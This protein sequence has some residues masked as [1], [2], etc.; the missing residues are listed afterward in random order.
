MRL[1]RFTLVAAALALGVAACGD[2]VQVVEPTPPQPPPPPPVEATMAPAS[3]S[4]AVGNSVVFAVNASGGVAGEAASWTCSSSNT[5]IATVTSTSAGC[6]ATGV[7]AGDVTITASVSKSGETVNVGAQLTVTD[8]AE[9][10]QPPGDPAFVVVA[11]IAGEG[12]TDVSGL[13]GRVSVTVNVERGG[14]E[15][16]ELALLVDGA[17]VASQS[18]GSP[19]MMPPEDEAAE[20]APHA[21]TMGF[22]SDGY[23]DDGTPDYMNGEHTISAELEIGVTMADGMHGHETVSSNV[24]TVEFDND[25][26][27][28]VSIAGLG[29]GAMNEETGQIWYGGPGVMPEI[30]AVPVSYS[31]GAIASLTLL[32]FCGADA[33]TDSEAPFSFTVECDDHTSGER[34]DTPEFTIGGVPANVDDE[35]SVYLDF[36]GPAAPHFSP[37]PNKREDGW[38]NAA[39]DFLGKQHGKRNP[40]GWL[41][42]NADKAGVGGYA[43]QLRFSDTTPS[44]VGGAIEATPNA[45]PTAAT[46]EDAVCVVATAVDL[47]G[48]ESSLPSAAAACAN[49]KTYGDA[50]TVLAA[51]KKAEDEDAIE[52]ALGDI[53]A[54]IRA[55]LDVTAPTIDFSGTSPTKNDRNLSSQ[56]QLQVADP[57]P[58]DKVGQSG[59]HTDPVLARVEIRNAKN[60]VICGDDDA[61]K[62]DLPGNENLLGVC[63]NTADGL[64]YD[65]VLDLVSTSGLPTTNPAYYTLTAVGRDKAGNHSEPVSRVALHDSSNPAASVIGGAYDPKKAVYNLIV[66]V[67]DNFSVRGYY[68]ALNFP[69]ASLLTDGVNTA[70]SGN[71][72]V[73]VDLPDVIR[74]HNPVAVDAY[75]SAELTKSVDAGGAYNAFLVLQGTT[76]TGTG[77]SGDPYV[78]GLVDDPATALAATDDRLTNT[79]IHARDQSHGNRSYTTPAPSFAPA[80]TSYPTDGFPE[81]TPPNTATE[82]VKDGIESFTFEADESTYDIEDTIELTA[83][84]VGYSRD[85]KQALV[86][87]EDDTADGITETND[88]DA[89]DAVPFLN[90]FKRVDFYAVSNPTSSTASELRF[91]ASVGVTGTASAAI[92]EDDDGV[93]DADDAGATDDGTFDTTGDED[94]DVTGTP[95]TLTIDQERANADNEVTFSYGI[96]VSAA[97][98]YAAVRDSGKG[99]YS[100]TVIA[101]GVSADNKDLTA[102][103]GVGLVSQAMS[104]MIDK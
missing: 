43:P 28:G 86:L 102:D 61:E 52:D 63:E 20:Q 96:E 85:A 26:F 39:V 101:I 57:N 22:D 62:K 4:V 54:G 6:S 71:A 38:V 95:Q 33:A 30:T 53:P 60:E 74:V 87:G 10:T 51:A 5:G 72:P 7:A 3:A 8:D 82:M 97:D 16:E 14:Q 90:P 47:L 12:D 73:V 50:V 36:E 40:D 17:V 67:T 24:V 9:P 55:G 35:V 58:G 49:A 80:S 29:D 37:N 89:A 42:Y 65:D 78:H 48:N 64:E 21:F 94:D 88:L 27:I 100:G 59:L 13:K 77:T 66:S 70:T 84:V 1:N 93:D 32:S 76:W 41:T 104:I 19:D 18:F 99:D 25:D 75:N 83:E 56:F 98:F 2:D 103:G 92:D 79:S 11:T 15:I 46:K 31:D 81:A 91:I 44:V 69:A 34:G 68:V 23:A 45:L